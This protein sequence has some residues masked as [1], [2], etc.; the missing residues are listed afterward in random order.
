META[1]DWPAASYRVLPHTADITL[2][3]WGR[4]RAECLA[5]AVNAL[6]C[7]FTDPAEASASEEVTVRFLPDCDDDLLADVLEEVIYQ[8]EVYER[9]PVDIEVT[10]EPDGD[11]LLHLATVA[12]SE[13]TIIG[14]VPKAVAL[15]ELDFGRTGGIWRCHVTVDV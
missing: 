6:V 7:T 4:S 5:Q 8:G 11:V 14:A 2:Q 1:G 9:V 13:V 10:E 15:H 12:T 3:A